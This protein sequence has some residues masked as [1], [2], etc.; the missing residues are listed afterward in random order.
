M[1]GTLS[2]ITVLDTMDYPAEQN[3]IREALGGFNAMTPGTGIS[4]GTGTVYTYDIRKVNTLWVTTIVIDL[5][6]LASSA[7]GDVIGKAS[8]ANCHLG[9][10]LEAVHGVSLGGRI[11]CI[12]A[13][14]GGEPDI[15]VYS[16]PEATLTE[17][18]AI[19]ASSGEA[20]L[21][22]AAADW[23]AVMTKSLAA[24]ADEQYL[25]LVASGGGDNADYTAGRFVIELFGE[26]E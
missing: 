1:P 24:V 20:V 7:A 19:S 3:A 17:D 12:E 4:T 10:Y 5:T 21:L 23:T 14:A 13:P 8:T 26:A 11:S 18:S 25:Y 22:D 16:A 2:R 9:Q 15:D 6:G